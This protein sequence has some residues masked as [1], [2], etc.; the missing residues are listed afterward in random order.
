MKTSLQRDLDKF[1]KSVKQADFNIRAVT[2]GAFSTARSKLNPEAFKRLNT[3]AVDTFYQEAEHYLWGGHRVLAV[4]GSRLVLPNH[5]SIKEE[6]GEHGF[7]PKADSIRSLAI[8]SMLYDVFNKVTIDS[9]IASFSV[10]ERALL[11]LHLSHVKQ[12][13]LLLLDRGYPSFWLLFLLQAKGIEYCVRLNEDGMQQVKDFIE[14]GEKE[15]TVRFTL[16]GKSRGHLADYPE[17]QV[18]GK[19]I[20][21]RLI[22]VDL[23]D[24][25]KEILCT[26]LLDTENYP[27]EEFEE[28][29][30]YRRDE[31]EA[32]KLLKCRI[33]L[34]DFSGKTATAVK[35]D[36]HAK[37]FLMS[38]CA[39][40]AHPIDEKVKAE[41]KADEI[42]KHGQK[43]N[44]TNALSMT[45]DILVATFLRQQ[46]EKAL[47]AFDDVVQKTR[48]VIRQGRHV[49]R[50]MKQKKRFSMNYKKL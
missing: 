5:R 24:G 16:P 21:C 43:I 49:E 30:H 1:F 17:Y 11:K 35:Q 20:S 13:D 36:F 23:G 39:I 32:Y 2:K 4:D 28:L 45:Q 9:Q 40:Y 10:S 3:V 41:Y 26:S 31:E 8:C 7:G 27:Q 12:G 44:R 50:K 22:T 25:K 42:R 15:R 48:E 34:E 38:L 18:K 19:E 37:I 6:F 46:Y 29:Y 14:G 33:E 47:Q